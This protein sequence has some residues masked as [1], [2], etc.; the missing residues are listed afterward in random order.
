MS[1]DEA[2]SFCPALIAID[3]D[4]TLLRSDRRVSPRAKQA[5]AGLRDAGVDV[6]LCTGRPPRRVR[7]IAAEL[8][9]ACAI[10]YQGSATY[11][12]EGERTEVHRQLPRRVVLELIDGL[13][14][15]LPDVMLALETDHG[16]YVDEALAA[17][18]HAAPCPGEDGPDGIG[19]V[20]GFVREGVIKLLVRHPTLDA[21]GLDDALADTAVYRTWTTPELLEILCED[22]NKQRTLAAYAAERGVSR[23]RVAAFGDQHNDRQMLAWA[24]LGVAMANGSDEARAAADLV[25]GTNDEDGVAVL[26]EAW[27]RRAAKPEAADG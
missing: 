13:R 2:A 20:R 7:A 6:T 23:E 26:L 1:F 22:V 19:D 25:T 11:H 8:D 24:G 4:G 15:A 3:L 17:S 16:W 10:V 18:G 5:I 12:A 21:R 14:S 27:L 9:L